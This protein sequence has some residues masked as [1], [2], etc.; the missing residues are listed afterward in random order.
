M[1]LA[2]EG[3]EGDPHGGAAKAAVLEEK[4]FLPWLATLGG[5]GRL[6]YEDLKLSFWCRNE[7]SR[8]VGRQVDQTLGLRRGRSAEN[9]AVRHI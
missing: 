7:V 9:M 8:D 2:E 3:E 5:R 4:S 1:R 6:G